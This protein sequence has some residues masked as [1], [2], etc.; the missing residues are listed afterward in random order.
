MSIQLHVSTP[1]MIHRV[2]FGHDRA[3]AQEQL[4]VIRPKILGRLS[5]RR[6]GREEE[7][8]TIKSPAGDMIVRLDAVETVRLIDSGEHH[9]LTE[10]DYAR[11]ID[12]QAAIA[13]AKESAGNPL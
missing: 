13:R 1:Y 5:M 4:E 2:A 6:N 11:E 7:T 12:F 10:D 3:A 8:H 9:R